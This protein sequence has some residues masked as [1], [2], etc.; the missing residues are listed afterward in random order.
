MPSGVLAAWVLS[1]LA[2]WSTALAFWSTA[3]VVL[4]TGAVACVVGA[5]GAAAG[6]LVLVWASAGRPA[7]ARMPASAAARDRRE[8]LVFMVAEPAI[9]RLGRR[10]ARTTASG[11]PLL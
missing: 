5:L 7:T 3:P 9:R 8:S 4:A 11:A 10:D 6:W 1:F 2:F